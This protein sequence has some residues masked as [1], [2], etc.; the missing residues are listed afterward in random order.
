MG[1]KDVND[2][3]KLTPF[4]RW[5]FALNPPPQ[6]QPFTCVRKDGSRFLYIHDLDAWE[7]V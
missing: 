6:V 4:E 5:G 7:E 2:W 3:K 1:C